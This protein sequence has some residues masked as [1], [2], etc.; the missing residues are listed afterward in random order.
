MKRALHKHVTRNITHSHTWKKTFYTWN[1]IFSL[2]Y[3]R[4]H[5]R[6]GRNGL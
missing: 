3:G 5:Q 2:L 4:Q 6:V 1:N